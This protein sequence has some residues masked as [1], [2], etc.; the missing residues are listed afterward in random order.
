LDK[1]LQRARRKGGMLSL[2]ILDLDHFKRINDTFG[3]LQGDVVLQKVALQLQKELRSYDVAARYGGEEFVAILPDTSLKEAFMVADR[4]RLS[5][6]GMN[7]IGPLAGERITG[8]LGIAAF[9]SPAIDDIDDLLRSA[10]EALYQAKESGRN[11]VMVSDP[12]SIK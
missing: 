6:Q 3:H 10:D 5:I 11:K 1:E 4:L 9:P 2:F 8:S 12:A 7:L